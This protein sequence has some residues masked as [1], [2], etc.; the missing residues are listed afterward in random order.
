MAV[1]AGA[2]VASGLLV[3][4]ASAIPITGDIGFDG[5]GTAVAGVVNTLTFNNPML[6][7]AR[8]GD[9]TPVP[10]LTPSNFAPISWIGSGITAVLT[11]VNSPEWTLTTGGTTYS[12]N[13]TALTSATL[14]GGAV[15]LQGT[16]TAFIA[17][18]INRDPTFAT[19]SVQGTGNNFTFRIVQS[20][21]SA[22]GQAVP[23]SGMTVSLLGLA[24]TGLGFARRKLA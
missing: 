9:Y 6:V 3:Q 2:I 13:L 7:G 4:N 5:T 20:S 19:F 1:F 21:T 11:S 16:G 12:F 22:N 15:S 18:A 23:D 8:N 17:G 10:S 14:T 24:V